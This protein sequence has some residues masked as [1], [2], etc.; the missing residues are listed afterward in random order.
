MW[1]LLQYVARAPSL[2]QSAVI[3]LIQNIQQIRGITRDEYLSYSRFRDW[4]YES[5][6]LSITNIDEADVFYV[7][8]HGLLGYAQI[9][10]FHQLHLPHDNYSTS[11]VDC[12]DTDRI[13][14]A[15]PDSLGSARSKPSGM[16]S[17]T[18]SHVIT[19]VASTRV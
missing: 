15:S 12:E 16:G 11:L 18:V 1:D 7:F 9:A 17:W 6:Q 8:S 13:S 4:C 14:Y 5:E 19:G 2:P 3:E 10:L